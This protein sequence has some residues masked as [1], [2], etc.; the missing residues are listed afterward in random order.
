M[1]NN[2][3]RQ[4]IYKMVMYYSDAWPYTKIK[5]TT[6]VEYSKSL[7]DLPPELVKLAFEKAKLTCEYFP[8]IS[9]LR[10][11]SFDIVVNNCPDNSPIPSAEEAWC[12]TIKC[13]QRE[14]SLKPLKKIHPLVYETAARMGWE[15][16]R[17]METKDE[18]MK[19]AIYMSSFNTFLEREKNRA[20]DNK[21]VSLMPTEKR[22]EFLET[23]KNLSYMNAMITSPR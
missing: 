21:L 9:Q 3:N 18:P 11:I 5:N 7:A 20:I 22:Q 1:Q 15:S 23:M 17:Y 19:R 2:S 14:T 16:L 8:K 12:E 4:I 13:I 6:A 10:E